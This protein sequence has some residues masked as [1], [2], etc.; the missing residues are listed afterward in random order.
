MATI[1]YQ[2][3]YESE[4]ALEVVKLILAREKLVAG[5]KA[6]I[7]GSEAEL[8]VLR[9]S[10]KEAK[11]KFPKASFDEAL[12]DI[13]QATMQIV[14]MVRAWKEKVRVAPRSFHAPCFARHR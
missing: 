11:A 12:D 6:V 4:A 8:A 9:A 13:R 3:G 14:I 7:E 1:S 5:L 2:S 10:G